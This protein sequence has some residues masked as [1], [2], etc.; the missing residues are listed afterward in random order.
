[1][2]SPSSTVITR[3]P[4]E[5][6]HRAVDDSSV[7]HGLFEKRCNP[8]PRGIRP[9]ECRVGQL[10]LCKILPSGLAEG[11]GILFLIQQIVDDLEGKTHGI[12]VSAKCVD[13]P[14]RRVG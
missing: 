3:D 13:R 9:E 14:L 2:E 4:C 12:A 11:R 5:I 6:V 10:S 1:M 8:G 7:V